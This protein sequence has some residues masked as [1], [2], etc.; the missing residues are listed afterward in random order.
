MELKAPQYPQGLNLTAYGT[1]MEGDL[2]EINTLNHY[3]G[4][5][6]I[7][8]DS[9]REL[10]LFPFAL[11]AAV[12]LVV[13]AAF[14]PRL[15]GLPLRGLA[16]LALWLFPVGFLVDLQWWLYSYGHNLRDTAAIRIDDFTP[17]V[18]GTTKVVN[19]HTETMVSWGWWL[20]LAGALLVTVGPWLTRFLHNAWTNTESSQP[21]SIAALGL[22]LL[23]AVV[24]F[25]PG[26]SNV[27]AAQAAP[28]GYIM[29]AIEAAA[30]GDTIA[31][32]A[33]TYYEQLVIEKSITLIGEDM[34]II[35]GGGSGHVIQIRAE[36]VTLRGFIVQASGR[37]YSLEPT[38]I[39]IEADGAT[40]EDNV[41]RDV[42][43]GIYLKDSH[44]HTVRRNMISSIVDLP[45]Q[46]RGHGLYLWNTMYNLVEAN[47]VHG[48]K[49]GVFLG[50]SYFTEIRGNTASDVRFGIH[51]MYADD[52][53]IS[54]NVFS[55]GVAGAAIMYSRRVELNN[56]EL[57]YNSSEA[58]GFGIL[59]KDVDDITIRDNLIHHNRLGI[60][61]EGAPHQPESFVRI[62]NNLVAYNQTALEMTT[63]TD[64]E[65]TG[66]S[67]LGNLR[68]V[69]AAGGDISGKNTWAIDGRGNYWDDYDGYDA[70]G[71]G[72]GDL[73]YRNQGS[74]DSL[75]QRNDALRA[76]Q[77][78]FAQSALDLTARWFP[79]YEESPR[80]TDPAPLMKPTMTLA[81]EPGNAAII[82]TLGIALF[83]IGVPLA[84]AWAARGSLRLETQP[85]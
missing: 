72:I 64:A 26:T 21:R 39:L 34:P 51:Y 37:A 8:P 81:Q 49:D 11:G 84:G 60:V 54:G 46:L 56:N 23:P 52:N 42:L 63:T 43:Y 38:G 66:N 74:F 50:F 29:S 45:A 12:L 41:V 33:G 27:R 13:V 28:Q 76:F 35:D 82:T 20:M 15:R 19:F 70:D 53:S 68:Q 55:G 83:L 1:R 18:L 2:Q 79:L 78:T 69:R 7:N 47:V 36:N 85:C 16:V 57:S 31:I 58:T 6:P 62:Q 73:S 75:V 24:A 40:I 5:E 30:P 80:I 32:P 44:N 10:D 17:K 9:V 65:F 67:F 22:L 59:L 48:A 14:R 71:D 25:V 61:M 3:V 77:Y 4:I